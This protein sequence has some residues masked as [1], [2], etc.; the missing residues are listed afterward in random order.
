MKEPVTEDVIERL[1]IAKGLLAKIRFSQVPEPDR[2]TLASYILTS[3]DAAEL[4]V[5]AIAQH[6]GKTPKESQ[7]YLMN[8]FPQIEQVHPG[9]RV[10]GLD[11]FTI[12]RCANRYQA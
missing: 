10:K 6:L 5:A 9:R 8:Y 12:E 2:I 4:A 11:F 3:H 7:A 1:L